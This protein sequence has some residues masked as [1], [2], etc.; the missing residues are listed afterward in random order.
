MFWKILEAWNESQKTFI[1]S[2]TIESASNIAQKKGPKDNLEFPNEY[3][4]DPE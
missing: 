4:R 3:Q 1:N 2:K